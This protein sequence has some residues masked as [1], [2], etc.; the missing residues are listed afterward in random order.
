VPDPRL[1]SLAEV[2]CG[3][4]LDVQPGEIIRISGPASS[5]EFIAAV[6]RHVTRMGGMPMPRPSF[7]SVEAVMLS[8]GSDE[9]LTTITEIDRLESEVPRKTLTIWADRNTRYMSE[10]PPERQALWS[11]ARREISDRFF[12]RLARGEI[13]WCGVTL[14]TQG[15][16][17]DAGMSLAEFE[18][19]VFGAGHVS[20][21]DP[22]AYWRRQSERQAEVIARL[23]TVSELRIVAEDTDLTL[24]VSGR[25]WQNADGRENF[26][27]GEVYTSPV[28]ERTRGHIAFSFDATYQG[29]EFGGVRLWFEDGRV[30]R[31]EATRGEEFLAGMLEMDEGARYV[32]EV[33]F[34]M[35]DEIQRATNNVA[36]D[37]KI[38][39]TTHIALGA[40]FPEAGGTNRSSLHWDIV[41]DLRHGG[42]VYGDGELLARDGAFL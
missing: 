4:S 30:V 34:G 27:D 20:D 24:D 28:H 5:H 19:F 16:A 14:P 18:D 15:F 7:P 11:R 22:V 10:V 33:A 8:R 35:N 38:G 3:Y 36:F 21:P 26:P 31:H 23:A 6:T 9:Q 42:E 25:T 32:G 29:R 2:I 39:G 37:E 17:Q 40:A 13:G 1:E 41:C 12:E